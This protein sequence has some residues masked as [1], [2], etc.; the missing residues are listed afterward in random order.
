MLDKYDQYDSYY[1]KQLDLENTDCISELYG[2]YSNGDL[3]G[4]FFLEVYQNTAYNVGVVQIIDS[5]KFYRDLIEMCDYCFM[6][7]DSI[8]FSLIDTLANQKSIHIL[9]KQKPH[10][11]IRIIG[12]EEIDGKVIKKYKCGFYQ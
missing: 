10:Y 11:Q 2:S 3:L 4:Y 5:P 6:F 12:E 7:L 9:M 8:Y 1:K